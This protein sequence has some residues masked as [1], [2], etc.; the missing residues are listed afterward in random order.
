MNKA[1][2]P[3]IGAP[4]SG[5]YFAGI[6]IIRE[7]LHALIVAPKAEGEFKGKW[8]NS[9]DKVPGADDIADG[10]SN[11]LAM[12]EAGSPI[13][14]QALALNIAGFTDWHV[15]SRDALELLYRHLKP[16]S[17]EN[18]CTFRD[19]ENPSSVPQGRFYTEEAPSVT[20]VEAFRSTEAFVA[21]WYWSSTQSSS[22]SAFDQDFDLGSQDDVSKSYEGRVRAVRTIQLSA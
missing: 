9:E 22:S 8:L 17:Q 2:L 1:D 11:T 14:K 16:T 5:G 7:A 3:T 12:A 4:L 20:A 13:A 6:L 21:G 15:P 10:L 18:Y 19:G